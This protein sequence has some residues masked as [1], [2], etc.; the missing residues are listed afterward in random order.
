VAKS[1]TPLSDPVR[2]YCYGKLLEVMEPI[3]LEHRPTELDSAVDIS[4]DAAKQLAATYAVE[5]ENAV[6]DHYSEPDKKGIRS[7]GP[8][9]KYVHFAPVLSSIVSQ[10]L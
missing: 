10:C 5:L 9:Y 3:F 2:K 6:F 1:P 4:D 7:P 8:K